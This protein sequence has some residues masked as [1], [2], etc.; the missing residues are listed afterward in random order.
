[1]P[2]QNSRGGSSAFRRVSSIGSFGLTVVFALLFGA[3]VTAQQV[4]GPAPVRIY[5]TADG[6]SR[7][8]VTQ[9]TTVGEMLTEH[10]IALNE[11]DRCSVPLS[12]TPTE[13]LRVV[14]NR[15][16]SEVVVEKTPVP[17]GTKEVFST[18]LRYGAKKVQ[19]PGKNGEKSVKFRDYYKDGVRTARV[20]LGESVTPAKP[21][22]VLVGTAGMTLAS[23]SGSP[24]LPAFEDRRVMELVA[25]GYGPSGNGKWGMITAT[26][27]R[28]RFGLVAVDPRVIPLGTPM[29][30]EGYGYCI[31]ADTGGAIKGRRID[32]F[33][34]SDYRASLVGRRRVKVIILGPPG[35]IPG[36][37]IRY[38]G[39]RVR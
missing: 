5:V 22:V 32:L 4:S 35:D 14:V 13:G 26:G 28:C 24:S 30:V 27:V 8:I 36:A 9:M 20:K 16:R 19:I 1:V 33:Y 18:E 38:R 11:D 34:E 17:F 10:D 25:T 39:R 37:R 12:T 6:E 21:A 23:R 7:E 31:A 2:F 29:F 15:V 3:G